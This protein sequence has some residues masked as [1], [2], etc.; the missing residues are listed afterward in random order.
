MLEPRGDQVGTMLE[1]R[2][3]HVGT[4]LEPCWN[5]P[6]H[7]V[8]TG[9][10]RHHTTSC[11]ETVE[12]ILCQDP[13]PRGADDHIRRKSRSMS[14]VIKSLEQFVKSEETYR[15][16]LSQRGA[17]VS[18]DLQGC[19]RVQKGDAVTLK[20]VHKRGLCKKMYTHIYIYIYT[21]SIL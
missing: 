11:R 3:N 15:T 19:R 12:G 6:E 4:M 1:P 13:T 5:H 9:V 18:S 16:Q 8:S 20:G 2:G 17:K 21:P 7:N 14:E 10:A